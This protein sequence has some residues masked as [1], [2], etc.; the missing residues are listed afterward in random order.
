[1]ATGI[2]NMD[3]VFPAYAGVIRELAEKIRQ[4]AR[5]PRVCGG[6]PVTRTLEASRAAVFPA[7]AGVIPKASVLIWWAEGCSPRMRG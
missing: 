4:L 2:S 5:V 6:D 3:V 1:M 7:Y